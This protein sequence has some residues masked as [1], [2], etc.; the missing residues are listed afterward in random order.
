MSG[1]YGDESDTWFDDD[2]YRSMFADPGGESALRA[3][4]ADN[5]RD[6]PCPN[7]GDKNVL[8]R[9]DEQR[10]YQ[11]NSCAT[12]AEGGYVPGREY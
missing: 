6:R 8:T 11:C 9:E 12:V 2:D 10:G 3:E 5:P 7:C 4:T 1:Y